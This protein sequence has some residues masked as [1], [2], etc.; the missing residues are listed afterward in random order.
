TIGEQSIFSELLTNYVHEKARLLLLWSNVIQTYGPSVLTVIVRGSKQQCEELDLIKSNLFSSQS[1][2]QVAFTHGFQ[3]SKEFIWQYI[4]EE[5]IT[6]RALA[7]DNFVVPK[8]ILERIKE[9]DLHVLSIYSQA[10]LAGVTY[11]SDIENKSLIPFYNGIEA[12]WKC[13]FTEIMSSSILSQSVI[14]TINHEIIQYADEQTGGLIQEYIDSVNQLVKDSATQGSELETNYKALCE[15]I[16]RRIDIENEKSNE[17]K[18]PVIGFKINI[19]IAKCLLESSKSE[20]NL[21]IKDN[22]ISWGLHGLTL[23]HNRSPK[24]IE[25]TW[26]KLCINTYNILDLLN[27]P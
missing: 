17:D 18:D 25:H 20:N 23:I 9:T 8:A 26:I 10:I 7:N 4:P 19:E 22:L 15:D 5:M 11:E 3:N 16:K 12:Y 27:T 21:Q 24:A 14:D 2:D 13:L 6:T 1:G